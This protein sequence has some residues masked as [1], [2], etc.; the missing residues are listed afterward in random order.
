ME[1]IESKIRGRAKYLK[2][3][4]SCFSFPL[5]FTR[6]K[7]TGFVLGPF[8]SVAYHSPYEWNR[9]ITNECNRA[10]GYVKNV[11]GG[12]QVYF[13]RSRGLLS[14]FWLLFFTLVLSV[15]FTAATEQAEVFRWLVSAA[16]SLVI[17]LVTALLDSLT[18]QGQE[19]AGIVTALLRDPEDFYY[20]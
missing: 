1:L 5:G 19:G 16:I 2:E 6:E 20:C 11:D 8:F 10:F 18:D 7:V 3:L 13:L 4:R 17:G 9:R 14:P 15:Y 12:V